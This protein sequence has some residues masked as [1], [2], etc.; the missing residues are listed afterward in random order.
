[1]MLKGIRQATRRWWLG[2]ALLGL[3]LLV[4]AACDSTNTYPIDFFSEMHYQKSWRFQEP[5]RLD[6]PASAVPI[7]G[8]EMSYTRDEAKN[9]QNPLANDPNARKLGQQL[10]QTNCVACHGPQGQGNGPLAAIWKARQG[11]VPPA[12]LTDQ[13]VA[14]LTD[15]ELYWVLTN[16]YT[17]PNNQI[18]YPGGL[19]NMPAF[20]KLLTPQE[21]WA[22]VTYIR[23]L[24]GK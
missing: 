21:R 11:A 20:G 24:E 7:T 19:T 5:P 6:S 12:N 13:A 17:S 10:Y 22:L 14:S 3:G 4:A 16:G 8:G 2:F 1:M 15:G 18:Q 9:L 23:Q